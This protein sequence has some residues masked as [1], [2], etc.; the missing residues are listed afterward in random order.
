M[1][2]RCFVSVPLL[3]IAACF[4]AVPAVAQAQ[5][6][7]L[8]KGEPVGPEP[9]ITKPI[10]GP[11]VYTLP[12]HGSVEIRCHL[13]G[14]MRI[15]NPEGG[16]AGEDEVSTFTVSNCH[17]PSGCPKPKPEVTVLGLPWHSHLIAGTPIRD[18][19]EG[20]GL[21]F[22]VCG[23]TLLFN[24]TLRP[25]VGEDRLIW[26][27]ALFPGGELNAETPFHCRITAREQ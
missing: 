9:G 7:W 4:A 8:N 6:H 15:W 21:E 24:G 22:K 3:V 17:S 25:A 2:K 20:I 16:G 1:I 11:V 14:Q 26:Q 13:R 5:P 10:G 19:I 18:E 27:E 23:Q 12:V